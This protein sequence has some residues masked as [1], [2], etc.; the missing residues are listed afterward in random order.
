MS[1]LTPLHPLSTAVTSMD[2]QLKLRKNYV[3]REEPEVS[4]NE[5]LTSVI[6]GL[7]LGIC[8]LGKRRIKRDSSGTSYLQYFSL[9]PLILAHKKHDRVKLISTV[10]T[11][12]GHLSKVLLNE[13]SLKYV[14]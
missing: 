14:V 5:F 10:S 9:L 13:R 6:P 2:Q 11:L 1:K 7:P 12:V 3:S 8:V 4:V